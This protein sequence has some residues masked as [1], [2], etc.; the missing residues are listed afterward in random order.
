MRKE[1]D[2]EY[3]GERILAKAKKCPHCRSWLDASAKPGP[4]RRWS[5][6][7]LSIP[8][9]NSLPPGDCCMCGDAGGVLKKKNFVY[10]PPMA[11]IGI[12]AGP[13]G[14]AVVT[15]ILQKKQSLYI[16]LCV[17]CGRRWTG[18][19]VFFISFILIGMI[20]CPV[21]GA[22]LGKAM[23]PR[24]GVGFGIVLGLIGWIVGI[25]MV[26]YMGVNQ[27]QAIVQSIDDD[28][29]RLK[30]PDPRVSREVLPNE[31]DSI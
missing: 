21:L 22:M 9:G 11:Y 7:V 31:S 15:T 20:A 30:F 16:P 4:K 10:V 25:F 3:C 24:N 23:S 28:F 1:I 8:I 17:S 12:L 18:F 6:D 14:L 5:G 27:N 26:K 19:Q 13:I 2:C 29:V